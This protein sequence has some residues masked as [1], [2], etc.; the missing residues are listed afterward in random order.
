MFQTDYEDESNVYKGTAAFNHESREMMSRFATIKSSNKELRPKSINHENNE[1][2]RL[3]MADNYYNSSR[4][5]VDLILAGK[6]ENQ[7]QNSRNI[8]DSKKLL[9]LAAEQADKTPIKTINNV[10][11]DQKKNLCN[12]IFSLKLNKHVLILY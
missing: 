2:K 7:L 10:Y 6:L 3:A 12:R 4:S 1:L 11:F 9:K 5:D 8:N